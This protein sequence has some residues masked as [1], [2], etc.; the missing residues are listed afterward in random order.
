MHCLVI[1]D[2]SHNR[3]AVA[4]V[5]ARHDVEV[6]HLATNIGPTGVRNAGLARFSTPLGAFVDYDVPPT[7]RA[8]L[9]L[10]RHFTDPAVASGTPRRT[11]TT[12]NRS[13]QPGR[14]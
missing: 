10:S 4:E 7:R 5:A 11:G 13:P 1:D 14:A 9:A 8:R 6:I 3:L 12:P 2:A